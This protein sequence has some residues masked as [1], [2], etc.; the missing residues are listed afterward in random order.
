MDLQKSKKLADEKLKVFK[1]I[2][3]EKSVLYDEM[4]SNARQLM[5]RNDLII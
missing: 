3:N 1:R 5:N 4:L 2:L